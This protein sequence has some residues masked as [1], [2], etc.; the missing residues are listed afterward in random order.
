MLK[1]DSYK[2]SLRKNDEVQVISGREK[3]KIGKILKVDLKNCRVLVEKTNLVKR[4]VRPTQKNSGGIVEK[5]LPLHYSN[6]LLLCPK[7]NRG[8]RH[9]IKWMDGV[10]KQNTKPEA[11]SKGQKKAKIRI[12]KRCSEAL[13]VA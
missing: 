7:C 4:H 9:G 3:G 12:C 13:D 5:E 6:V 8:V 1:N 10:N 2:F 11:S